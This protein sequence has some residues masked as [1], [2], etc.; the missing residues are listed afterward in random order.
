MQI[1][2]LLVLVSLVMAF[3]APMVAATE[4]VAWLPYVNCNNRE[5]VFG[6]PWGA[7]SSALYKMINYPSSPN[8]VWNT[9]R[10]FISGTNPQQSYYDTGN[11]EKTWLVFIHNNSNVPFSGSNKIKIEVLL[12]NGQLATGAT[13]YYNSTDD[14]IKENTSPNVEWDATNNCFWATIDSHCSLLIPS[15]G[16]NNA[17]FNNPPTDSYMSVALRISQ[18]DG[19]D[20]L[21]NIRGQVLGKYRTGN[22]TFSDKRF[23]QCSFGYPAFYETL[24]NSNLTTHKIRLPH[25][26]ESYNTTET[27]MG[28]ATWC[29]LINGDGS[30][31]TSDN[32]IIRVYDMSNYPID[33][34]T[35]TLSKYQSLDFTPSQFFPN[36]SY[37]EGYIEIEGKKPIASAL[38]FRFPA[39][40]SS[41][42]NYR[43]DTYQA[44]TFFAD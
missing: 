2:K 32:Y 23:I 3:L 43:M 42:F 39:A 29:T 31:E 44:A 8:P 11:S 22:G 28:W 15:Y 19:H 27:G 20:F 16:T 9:T 41:N 40:S 38:Q 17:L 30:D 13:K 7:S 1:R 36:E 14:L 12:S 21:T 10:V 25:F 37:S 24:F 34:K 5:N 4:L 26:R 6:P 33:S 18:P 35:V